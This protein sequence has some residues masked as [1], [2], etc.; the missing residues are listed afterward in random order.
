MIE[1]AHAPRPGPNSADAEIVRRLRADPDPSGVRVVTSDHA[2]A[3]DAR[4]LGA[5]VEPA[6]SF[7]REIEGEDGAA[8]W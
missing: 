1:V 2:L 7:R 6:E 8:S 4:F 5:L 3:D